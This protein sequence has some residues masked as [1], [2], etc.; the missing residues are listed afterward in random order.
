MIRPF[1]PVFAFLILLL[2]IIPFSFDFATSV[3]P[4][5]HMTIFPPSFI[6]GLI[7]IIVFASCKY[8]LLVI[9]YANR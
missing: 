2:L 5:W 8:R 3:V 6:W 7:S 4:G 1:L 9:L